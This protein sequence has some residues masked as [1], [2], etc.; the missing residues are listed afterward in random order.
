VVQEATKRQIAY[1]VRI[2]EIVNGNYVK[3]DGW[4]P[5][6]I[7]TNSG[8]ELSRVNVIGTVVSEPSEEINYMSL[9]IDDGSGKISL[10]SFENPEI[11][12]G[13]SIG[14][15]VLVIGRPR[16]FNNEKY[17]LPEI[18]KKIKNNKWIEVRRLELEN[19]L[20]QQ[21]VV[22]DVIEETPKKESSHQRI[23]NLIKELDDGKGADHDLV[24]KKAS[25][26]DGEEIIMNLL[27][28]GEIFEVSPG[29]LKVLE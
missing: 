23:Y 9:V 18:L 5:N 7:V 6:V 22:E 2:S 29:K 27:K 15:V 26:P 3:K 19:V 20:P 10:K 12:K 17:I 11:F 24:L 13:I 21:E 8:K 28:E 1:K 16:E 25:C 4:L 14:D